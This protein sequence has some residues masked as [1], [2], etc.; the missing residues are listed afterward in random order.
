MQKP[1]YLLLLSCASYCLSFAQRLDTIK[2]N[3]HDHIMTLYTSGVGKPTVV[4]EAGGGSNHRTWHQ[5]L[6]K[7][8]GLLLLN[9]GKWNTRQIISNKAVS[10]FTSEQ[11]A[12]PYSGGPV[13]KVGYGF[14]VWFTTFRNTGTTPLIQANGN[15][16]QLIM[17]N[18]ELEL[19][20]VVTA[21]NYNSRDDRKQSDDLYPDFIYPSV[22]KLK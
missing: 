13:S 12:T 5:F 20:A 22:E 3:V 11:I 7:K 4:L 17:I 1:F 2:V 18:K 6:P 21:G 10:Q 14:Q 15:G 16:G 19:V 8:F 9:G